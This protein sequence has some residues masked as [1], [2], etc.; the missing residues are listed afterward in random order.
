ME[1]RQL[2]PKLR[3]LGSTDN[4]VRGFHAV[5]PE[6]PFRVNSMTDRC[7]TRRFRLDGSHAAFQLSL[8]RYTVRSLFRIR[9]AH[10][11]EVVVL[12]SDALMTHRSW[13][14][15]ASCSIASRES[16]G[17]AP[18]R[19]CPPAGRPKTAPGTPLPTPLPKGPSQEMRR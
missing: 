17:S 10:P 1:G 18:V 2:I 7:M 5:E 16:N 13:T 6:Y 9:L 11:S 4:T 19:E 15:Y 8:L 12:Q 14:R 3:S